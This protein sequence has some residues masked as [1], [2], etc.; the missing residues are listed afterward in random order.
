MAS[1]FEIGKSAV[2]AQRQ[3]LNVTGQN[4]A[5]VNTEG[6]RK[7]DAS[8][9]EVSGS[10]SELTSIA[11]QVG[12]GVS[13]GTVRRAYN[14]FLASS[15]NTAES[16]FQAATE[17]SA[18]MERLE[19]L[20]LPGEGDLSQQL[21]DF[22]T[23]MSDIAA[24]PGDL[25]PRAA[26][27]E[28]GNS[29][30]NAF[31]VTAQV[32]D[33]LEYQFSGTIDQEADEVNRL[34]DSLGVVNGR[35][36]SSNIGA[37]PPN[38]LLDERDRL[39]TEISKRVR[40][41]T[42]FGPRYDVDV[43]LGP[44]A[45]GPQILEGET[46]YTLKPIHSES[47]GVV[48]RLGS[49]AIVKSLEDGSMKGLSNALLVIQGT[50]TQLDALTNRFVSEINAAHT[51]GIDFDGDLGKELFT[52]RAFSL[53]QAKTNSQVLD[54]NVLEVPGKIDQVPDATFH[55]SAATASWNAYDLNNKLLASGRSQIDMGGVIVQ[56]NTRARDGDSFAMQATSGEASRMQFLL[57]NGR[58]IAAASNY[59]VTPNSANTGSSFLVAN[60]QE[61]KPLTINPMVALTIN[62]ISPVS[63]TEF[64]KG[65]AVGYIPA[66]TEQFQLASFGQDSV[67]N[68]NFN[69]MEGLSGF[70]FT[71]DGNTYSFPETAQSAVV[72]KLSDTQELAEYLNAG[73]LTASR[74][75]ALVSATGISLNDLGLFASGFDGGLKIVG[76]TPF[77]S[78][79]VT[80]T[81][82]ASADTT[83]ATITQKEAASGFRVFTR[84]GRQIS[85]LP[86]S[87]GDANALITEE[88]GFNR[89]ASYRA[90]YLNAIGGV[91][92]RG[93]QINNLIPGGYAA[94]E[95]AALQL[96]DNVPTELVAQ[97]PALNGMLAQILTFE[98]TDGLMT[99]EVVLQSGLSMKSVAAAVNADLAQYG[100]VAD[101]KTMASVE[102]ASGA[103]A[104]GTVSFSLV[105]PDSTEIGFSATYQ[106][107]DL[108]PLV[109]QINQRQAQTGVSAEVS[110][111]G[112]R[113]ILTQAEGLDISITNASGSAMVVNSLDHN[114]NKLL[115][116]DVSLNQATK[117][118]GSLSFQ[119]PREF[120][121]TSSNGEAQTSG[122]LATRG[123]GA[124]KTY[125]QA[126]T[127]SDFTMEIAPEHLAPQASPNG[128]RL[129]AS[130]ATFKLTVPVNN[131][132]TSVLS[133][134]LKSK[135]LADYSIAS[136]SKQLVGSVRET[137]VKPT[138]NGA[139]MSQKPTDGSSMSVKVGSSTYT[140]TYTGG[141]MVV[142][143]PEQQRLIASLTE[144]AGSPTT[145]TVS[146]AAPGGVM[147]GRSIE[148]LD[149]TDA[150][151]FG[152]ASTD[153]GA[154]A[155]LQ[156]TAFELVDG[157]SDSFDVLVGSNTV[158]VSVS[159]SGDDY[160]LTSGDPA[161][162]QFVS[163][164]S[165]AA[166]GGPL[167]IESTA[168][169][170]LLSLTSSLSDGV[171]KVVASDNAA[172][173]GMQVADLD[174]EVNETGFRAIST[175][176][177][178]A[179]VSLEI[180]DLPGQVLS[181]SGLPDEDFII[182]LEDSGAKRLA[183]SYDMPSE[184]VNQARD[185]LKE[186]RVK[187]V[188]AN[189]GKIELFDHLTGDSIAT[190]YSSGVAEF[191]VDNFRFELAGFGDD[192]D[193][194]DVSLNR[195]SAGDGR[196]MEAMIDLATRTPS[197]P[198]FQD[199]FR[200][201]ALAVGSQLESARL[202]EKSATSLRDAAVATEDELSGV[203][204]DEEA[205][206]L[207]EQQQ[208]YKAAAQILNS[209]REMFDTLVNIM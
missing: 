124:S 172:N 187:V 186:F 119:S 101:A 148:V 82:G 71:V 162:L 32:L 64:L 206:K 67:V 47:D 108:S 104:S 39:I 109:T 134:E 167:T 113:L 195:S 138:L 42:T 35:L 61:M 111:D 150:A 14:S 191:E 80:V 192:G 121:V 169:T 60:P 154:M 209:A 182:L 86:L 93:A 207:L 48:Y 51:A 123:G 116:T 90:D 1:L 76:Q 53:E 151:E 81:S 152:L 75:G 155:L 143:G 149:D 37:A 107:S 126:G 136:I 16:R 165:G 200:A 95:T 10:Q 54:I 178:P 125:A 204:L 196:N 153:S 69:S 98:T 66:G 99:Q 164:V 62:S 188:D 160:E 175:G 2:N 72:G 74:T 24:N 89:N 57:K 102:L 139:A 205:G 92:Y 146:L 177:D 147:S 166:T 44:H 185:E 27:L 9:K 193:Y 68:L 202:I 174:F 43:R 208:A 4:I 15:T 129:N 181:M 161:L 110:A 140:V 28:Q 168:N 100:I 128:M 157:A 25:A 41:T 198:S 34:V 132:E 83:A 30:A 197:R 130:S 189:L 84:E 50:Q 184:E 173:L 179:N 77:T 203:N 33:D 115:T 18:A 91:G 78:G 190:R 73:T 31:N 6:Y 55:Y 58:E 131:G 135:D 122:N 49:K 171:I 180:D 156:G 158:A 144:N 137:A 106:S 79:A 88:N 141:E 11:A 87:S 23:K 105:T 5:N 120:T 183:S 3:A 19:N 201:I 194:F 142:S 103:A 8:L 7:R 145:Y 20:I 12:L 29:L 163:P 70:E 118:I 96:M 26:A 114:Y 85:G 65:G 133:E 170:P 52:A 13:L 117:V 63:Y 45:S 59:I 97:N 159:R 112:T 176:N 94:I 22:F 56:V 40:I 21:S 127:I 36:R 17:F 199:D 38:A 46:S